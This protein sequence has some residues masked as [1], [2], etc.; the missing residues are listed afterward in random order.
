MPDGVKRLAGAG[1]EV[2]VE[3]GAGAARLFR[4]RAYEAAGATS[5]PTRPTPAAAPTSSPG[6]SGRRRARSRSSTRAARSWRCSSRRRAREL[7]AD[8][9]AR[10][11]TRVRARAGAAHHARADHGRALVAGDRRRLQGGAARRRREL[12]RLLPMLTTAAGTIPPAQGVRRSA[13][14]S[15][16]CRRSPPR[17]GSARWCSAFDVRAAAR[18]QVQSLGATFVAAELVSAGA[19]TAGG[20]ARAQTRRRAAAR[21]PTRSPR[22]CATW[23]S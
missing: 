5:P 22:T 19:E 3:R 13:P 14:A 6:C 10:G 8:L 17:G 7:L 1:H 21:A 12:P 9:A 16:G 18:E 20:Y 11:V 23:T 2:V 4:R 15:P